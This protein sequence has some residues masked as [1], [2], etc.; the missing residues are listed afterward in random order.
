MF[1]LYV[2]SKV[3]ADRR[4]FYLV[5]VVKVLNIFGGNWN[6]PNQKLENNIV[7]MLEPAYKWKSNKWLLLTFV[8]G[9][10]LF[11]SK[12]PKLNEKDAGESPKSKISKYLSCL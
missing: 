2:F 5:P 11:V 6:S 10:V 12:I 4:I 8:L 3:N 7:L 9:I 1:I